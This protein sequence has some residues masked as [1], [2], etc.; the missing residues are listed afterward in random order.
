MSGKPN[1]SLIT[2]GHVWHDFGL[3]VGMN[4]SFPV[5]RNADMYTGLDSDINFGD[6]D[7]NLN[8]WIP[9]GVELALKS[10]ISFLMEGEIPITTTAYFVFG[11][12][13]LF[14]F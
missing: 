13:V 7:T 12:G 11:G 9:V 4:I 14:Y 1:I 6:E 2:G 5:A 3:D 8:V 10:R